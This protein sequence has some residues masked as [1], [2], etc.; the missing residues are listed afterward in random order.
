MQAAE[1]T[2]QVARVPHCVT[3]EPVF[4]VKVKVKVKT[5]QATC[6]Q[7]YYIFRE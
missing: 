2:L 5:T 6:L 7:Y 3:P 4:K 1:V